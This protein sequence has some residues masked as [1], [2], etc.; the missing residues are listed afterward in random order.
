MSQRCVIVADDCQEIC[1]IVANFLEPR[2]YLVLTAASGREV[3]KLL[4]SHHCDL[5]IT[6]VL[7]PDGDGIELIAGLKEAHSPTRILAISGGGRT[8]DPS[9]CVKLAKGMGAHA[10]IMKPFDQNQLLEAVELAFA[11]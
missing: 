11:A 8:L 3:L 1:S 10:G 5:L 9:Y 2:G 7:M 4:R 6:D